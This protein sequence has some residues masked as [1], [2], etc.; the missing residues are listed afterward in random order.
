MLA[1]R[2]RSTFTIHPLNT[3]PLLVAFA[4]GCSSDDAQQ[5]AMTVDT[6]G[7]SASTLETSSATSSS[8]PTTPMS[9]G[10]D[11]DPTSNV[12][13]SSG[14]ETSDET[15]GPPPEPP[16]TDTC[17]DEEVT[18]GE[19]CFD[20]A[21]WRESVSVFGGLYRGTGDCDGD[22]SAEFFIERDPP[23]NDPPNGDARIEIWSLR[24]DSFV[25]VS[26]IS[27]AVA[28]PFDTFLVEDFDGDGFADVAMTGD[29][30]DQIDVVWLLRS[31]GGCEFAP[32]IL[33]GEHF[34]DT[35]T[36]D[37]NGDGIQD[38]LAAEITNEPFIAD[39]VHLI[40]PVD[41]ESSMALDIDTHFGGPNSFDLN[42]LSTGDINGDG[43]GDVVMLIREANDHLS[44]E[45]VFFGGPD[46][47]SDYP[48]PLGGYH[49]GGQLNLS[50]RDA[51]G[52]GLGDVTAIAP[53]GQGWI[54]ENLGDVFS[55][56][57]P[58]MQGPKALGDLNND[59]Q[60]EL[61]RLREGEVAVYLGSGTRERW[62]A[63]SELAEV[64]NLGENEVAVR[65][66]DFNG[67]GA[68]DL[69]IVQASDEMLTI[70]PWLASP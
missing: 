59:G 26:E 18:A 2:P 23:E 52:D 11:T 13:G 34:V 29:S 66:D 6:D 53:D 63:L 54:R 31:T 56:P 70:T 25:A 8:N 14:Q 1:R 37:I 69:L 32:Q 47:L 7:D 30:P 22:G 58:L 5:D 16:P 35:A 15:D 4:S 12:D 51:N 33:T 45:Y 17:S 44:I 38:L 55:T 65:V 41:V 48:S 49:F 43:F 40:D 60:T 24:G 36:V 10:S 62:L 61:V 39:E 67:D 21:G 3:L 9:E 42:A 28:R 64:P 20:V 27:E 46:G 19:L 57:Q 68:N 50:H